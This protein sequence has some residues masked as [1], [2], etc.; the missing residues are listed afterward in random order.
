MN[1]SAWI[2]ALLAAS[3]ARCT[4]PETNPLTNAGILPSSAMLLQRLG[5]VAWSSDR[6]GALRDADLV[7]MCRAGRLRGGA[8][9][10]H[11]TSFRNEV[12][13]STRAYA[14]EAKNTVANLL[15]NDPQ[16]VLGI[17]YNEREREG[18]IHKGERHVVKILDISRVYQ[19]KGEG[20]VSDKSESRK[21]SQGKK[22]KRKKC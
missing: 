2:V 8:E 20:D 22:R 19:K 17:K 18:G 10:T 9:G 1:K 4:M 7:R 6:A 5:R 12:D 16:V 14:E 15:R 3:V 13:T 11:A 21:L